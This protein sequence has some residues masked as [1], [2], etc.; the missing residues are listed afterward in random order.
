MRVANSKIGIDIELKM[1]CPTFLVIENPIIKRVLVEDIWGQYQGEKGNTIIS[2][3]EKE[4]S[5]GKQVEI[6]VNPFT[7]DF[8]TRKINLQLL[9]EAKEVLLD[10]EYPSFLEIRAKTISFFE[11]IMSK[12]P[13]PIKYKTQVT[14]EEFLKA[15]DI[16]VETEEMELSERVVFFMEIS[17]QILNTKIFVLVDLC[18][19]FTKQELM[20][21]VKAGVYNDI[22]MLFI[23]STENYDLEN[24]QTII[25]DEDQCLIEY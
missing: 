23:E 8:N 19:Y 21:I 7:I 10:Y 12:L 5:N 2:D 25:I 1:D 15:G 18:G 4:L 14:P 9:E 22:A 3:K 17:R 16:K 6:I 11:R 20:E 24:K 13:Y